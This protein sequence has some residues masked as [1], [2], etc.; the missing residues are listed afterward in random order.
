MKRRAFWAAMAAA[1]MGAAA[2]RAAD[3]RQVIELRAFTFASEEKLQI[4]AGLIESALIP[5]M[6]RAGC[7][8]VGAFRAF[9]AD[10]PKFEADA[11]VIYMV[12]PHESFETFATLGGRLAADPD[13][14]N[15]VRPALDTPMK[16]PVYQRYQ[17]QL[18]IG[19]KDWPTVE[20]PAKG[21]DRVVQL[22]IY[23][24]HNCEK[25]AR[26]IAM[27]NE[28][29]E[30]AIF[31][32]VGLNPVFFGQSLAGTLMPNLTYMLAFD[33]PAAMEAAWTAFR[34]DPEWVRLRDD[35]AYKDTVSNITNIVLRPLP[36]SQI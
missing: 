27:F 12:V 1:A 13:I 23:E 32:R 30:I 9:K 33:S 24:S 11:L 31:R 6:N 17:S 16:D 5:A 10:N 26:K 28:G 3:G 35:P 21:P 8:P 36:G 34:G 15:V 22:R 2:A 18:M 20:A 19:F 7:R 25:A 29:G 14:L 4:Y